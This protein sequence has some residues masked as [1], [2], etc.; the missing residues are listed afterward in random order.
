MEQFIKKEETKE[1]YNNWVQDW[2]FLHKYSNSSGN[3]KK[4]KKKTDF[5]VNAF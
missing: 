2:E 4:K 1:S 5:A 3:D